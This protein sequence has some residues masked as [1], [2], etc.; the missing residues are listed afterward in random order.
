MLDKYSLRRVAELKILEF[1]VSL[2]YYINK[3]ARAY[4]FS[5][6]C[7]ISEIDNV[8]KSNTTYEI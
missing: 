8:Y 4:I 1:L 6:L 2:K 7:G 3:Y 5:I